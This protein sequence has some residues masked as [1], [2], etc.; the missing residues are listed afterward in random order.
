MII[1]THFHA[2]PG[3]YLDLMANNSTGYASRREYRRFNH[4]EYL[5]VLDKWGTA[6]PIERQAS[7]GK[8]LELCK[9]IND[10]FA[11][12]HAKHPKR[13]MAFARLPMLNVVGPSQLDDL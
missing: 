8:A 11:E 13:F 2:F 7:K 1:D 5:E 4:R 9:A 12:A 6:A 3:K 10:A